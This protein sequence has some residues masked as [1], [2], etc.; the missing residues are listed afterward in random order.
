M[1]FIS[2]TFLLLRVKKRIISLQFAC[3]SSPS[4]SRTHKTSI[5]QSGYNFLL[6]NMVRLRGTNGAWA[7]VEGGMGTVTRRLA[8]NARR[9]GAALVSGARVA[10]IETRSSGGSGGTSGGGADLTAEGVVLSC[11]RRVRARVGVVVACD[12]W[13]LC[14]MSPA[15]AAAPADSFWP[16]VAAEA[17]AAT[18]S[19][20][21]S[22]APSKPPSFREH[23]DS[24]YVPATTF[25]LNLALSALPAFA[26]LGGEREGGEGGPEH[27]TTAHLLASSGGSSSSSSSPSPV[28]LLHDACVA[29]LEGEASFVDVPSGGHP[30]I[31]FYFH[32][33]ADPSVMGGGGEEEGSEKKCHSAALFVQLAPHAPGV[34][35]LKK[36]KQQQ[37]QRQQQQQPL[38]EATG[39]AP[40]SFEASKKAWTREAAEAYASSLLAAAEAWCPGLPSLVVDAVP[41]PP[42]AIE[43][44]FGISGGA[45]FFLFFF[46]IFFFPPL[47][48]FFFV[49]KTHLFFL[50]FLSLHFSIHPSLSLIIIIK[51]TSTTC[52]TRG[53]SGSACRCGSR[54]TSFS[55][56]RGHTRAAASPARRATTPPRLSC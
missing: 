35:L 40:A 29:A 26:C 46:L 50:P 21:S 33:A 4:F 17:A 28:D 15:L 10:E 22:T 45:I 6:H 25:K 30:P 16:S 51:A 53:R 32:S 12:P 5:I 47:L 38:H 55:R 11:G 19:S 1:L 56:R 52:R 43:R 13:A 27:K 42:P 18:S 41:Y 34:S 14:E 37:R 8:E 3:S 48:V 39:A 7:L 44:K 23:L 36:E 31:E 24:L 20:S 9:A 49:S 2:K 54:P